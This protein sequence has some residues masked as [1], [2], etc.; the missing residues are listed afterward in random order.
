[1]DMA[2]DLVQILALAEEKED[3]N[4]R[5]RQF[6]KHQC[7]LDPSDVDTQVMETT[8]RVWAGPYRKRRRESMANTNEA[9]PVSE[10]EPVQRL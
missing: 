2:P 4:W 5:F 10:G 1:M 9:L 8:K 3:E 7:S 6:L